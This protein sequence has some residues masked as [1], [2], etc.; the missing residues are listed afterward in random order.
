MWC[1][2][3]YVWLDV[4]VQEDNIR[5]ASIK[6]IAPMKLAAITNRGTKKDFVDIYVLLNHL[7]LSEMLNLYSQKYSQD[8]DF[9]V[10]RSLTYFEDAEQN[11]DPEMLTAYKWET[12]KKNY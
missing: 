11:S 12:I 3:L 6:D 7:S 9:F 4:P 10:L 8:S 2:I 1:A 5:L